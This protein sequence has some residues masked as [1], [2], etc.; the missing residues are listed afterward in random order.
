MSRRIE[1]HLAP[2]RMARVETWI[3]NRCTGMTEA[4]PLEAARF[5]A[6][7]LAGATADIVDHTE[8]ELERLV[9]RGK[10]MFS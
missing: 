5:R 2:H 10:A 6:E 9:H 7:F 1:I 4:L 8:H 3:D